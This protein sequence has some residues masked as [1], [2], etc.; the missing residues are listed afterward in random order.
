MRITLGLCVLLVVLPSRLFASG[1]EESKVEA[2]KS[3]TLYLLAKS[4]SES[5]MFAVD[6]MDIPAALSLLD[7]VKFA[8]NG[9]DVSMETSTGYRMKSRQK[10]S[11]ARADGLILLEYR[12][13]TL[14]RTASR[15]Q[16]KSS[17]EVS[18]TIGDCTA[19]NGGVLFQPERMA[20]IRAVQASKRGSGFAR[21]AEISYQGEGEFS[22]RVEIR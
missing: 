5:E 22:A 3:F 8:W 17:I 15:E 20:V 12:V 16:A 1:T 4:E 2:G 6:R 14:A 7:W 9:K 10:V 19:K 21:V 11:S 18:F 13:S